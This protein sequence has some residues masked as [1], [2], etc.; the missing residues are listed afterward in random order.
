MANEK[1]STKVPEKLTPLDAINVTLS[2]VAGAM[3]ASNTWVSPY[4][5][6]V[7]LGSN[8]VALVA[9]IIECRYWLL[10]Q[11][12]G[13]ALINTVAVLRWLLHM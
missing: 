12:G 4:G 13:F 9:F 8:V 7:M 6:A 2:L 11:A 3:L 5:F 10:L 1:C